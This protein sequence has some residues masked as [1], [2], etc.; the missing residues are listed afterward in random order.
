MDEKLI[1]DVSPVTF[2]TEDDPFILIVHGDADVVVPIE[3]AYSLKKAMEAVGAPVELLV[4]KGGNHGVAGASNEGA[5]ERANQIMREK[6][7]RK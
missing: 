1:T 7:L 4:V 3:H 2:V 6:L 5:V